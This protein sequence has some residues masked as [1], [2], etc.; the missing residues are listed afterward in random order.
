[1]ARLY[2]F[3]DFLPAGERKSLTDAE[4]H[5][6][7]ETYLVRN[8]VE[9]EDMHSLDREGRSTKPKMDLLQAAIQ[10]EAAEYDTGFELP[11]F[12]TKRVYELFR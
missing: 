10:I 2:W 1:M 8:E 5:D 4:I 12:T 11:D 6:L 9:V 7:I 3:H